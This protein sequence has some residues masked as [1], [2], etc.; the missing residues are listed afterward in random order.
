MPS[1]T[2]DRVNKLMEAEGLDRMQAINVARAE[3]RM[4]SRAR[5][6]PRAFD[7]RFQEA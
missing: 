2:E 1:Y 4:A 7:F 6:S 5:R 3:A